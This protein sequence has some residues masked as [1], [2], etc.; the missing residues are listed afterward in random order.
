MKGWGRCHEAGGGSSMFLVK[1]LLVRE[2]GEHGMKLW[3]KETISLGSPFPVAP[4]TPNANPSTWEFNLYCMF[5]F[6][7]D[8]DLFHV[9]C[10]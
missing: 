9:G 7:L 5:H 6:F 10:F 2:F 3:S 4:R 1:Q 8:L